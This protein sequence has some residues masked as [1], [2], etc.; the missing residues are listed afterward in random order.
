MLRVEARRADARRADAA[1]A[2]EAAR[3]AERAYAAAAAEGDAA[4]AVPW[5]DDIVD[6]RR[7]R[8]VE[9]VRVRAAQ[10]DAEAV[11]VR[12]LA[13]ESIDVDA[14]DDVAPRDI[15][16]DAYRR[17][18]ERRQRDA[19]A[20][21][22]V[23]AAGERNLAE[24]VDQ[25]LSASARRAEFDAGV[26]LAASRQ[27]VAVAVAAAPAHDVCGA[28][29][30]ASDHAAAAAEG[31][32]AGIALWSCA[33][34]VNIVDGVIVAMWDGLPDLQGDPASAAADLIATQQAD[35]LSAQDALEQAGFI[36]PVCFHAKDLQQ[37]NC[38]H[39]FCRDCITKLDSLV[40]PLCRH[41]I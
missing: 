38:G 24:I 20:L 11:R 12:S 34:G 5:G 2:I 31:D 22:V 16:V 1:T 36:C 29:A 4:D 8:V 14:D 30:V 6:F 9:A 32:A 27:D 25:P 15:D 17:Q 40:C 18:L 23:A 35:A 3:H 37:L 19:E 28:A 7:L 10:R 21:A 26:Q 13:A 41:P 39:E 33:H